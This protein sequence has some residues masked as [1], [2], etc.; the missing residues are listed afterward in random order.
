MYSERDGAFALVSDSFFIGSG[1][2][3]M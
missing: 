1:S 2:P 3:R